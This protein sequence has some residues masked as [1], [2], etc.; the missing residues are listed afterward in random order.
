MPFLAARL[1]RIKPSPTIGVTQKA[2]ELK[3]QGRDI[4]ASMISLPVAPTRSAA[5][6][7][8]LMQ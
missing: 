5:R 7:W 2:A 3:A 6:V 1:G 4:I 8:P